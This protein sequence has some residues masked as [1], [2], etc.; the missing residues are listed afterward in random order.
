MPPY[1]LP[2]YPIT[3]CP[4]CKECAERFYKILHGKCGTHDCMR[5]SAVSKISFAVAVGG[6]PLHGIAAIFEVV[7]VRQIMNVTLRHII[8]YGV[9]V[10]DP[11]F[12]IA[13]EEFLSFLFGIHKSLPGAADQCP[14]NIKISVSVSRKFQIQNRTDMPVFPQQICI[15]KIPMAKYGRSA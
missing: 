10:A 15:V 7:A 9:N 1:I 8:C 5:P 14:R 11:V 13:A 6:K 4:R 12:L 2:F 3:F